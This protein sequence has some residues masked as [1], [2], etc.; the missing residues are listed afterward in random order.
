MAYGAGGHK[1]TK[2]QI[3]ADKNFI[4]PLFWQGKSY[5]EITDILNAQPERGYTS[6]AMQVYKDMQA[7]VVEWEHEMKGMITRQ[8]IIEIKKLDR[9][10]KMY[11]EGYERSLH[12]QTKKKR[13]RGGVL[14]ATGTMPN[15]NFAIEQTESASSVGDPRWLDGAAE[16]MRQR[17]ELMNLKN[18]ALPE[19]HKVA[20]PGVEVTEIIF[21]VRKPKAHYE[22]A[23]EV[24]TPEID[25]PK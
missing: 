15:P 13:R 1:R 16:V 3:A 6:S 14:T 8:L 17:R 18:A 12:E 20:A 5:R 24:E 7:V 2:E 10:E 19:P 9:L 23:V 11:L 22:D 4:V 25:A 21:S